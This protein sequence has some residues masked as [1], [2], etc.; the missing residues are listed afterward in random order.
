MGRFLTLQLLKSK[1]AQVA[2]AIATIGRGY[3]TR[4]VDAAWRREKNECAIAAGS[5]HYV[6]LPQKNRGHGSL[7]ILAAYTER[8]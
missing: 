3:V 5:D 4:A 8:V 1:S 7:D 2:K 6:K